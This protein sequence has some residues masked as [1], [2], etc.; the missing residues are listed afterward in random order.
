M[1][2]E[3]FVKSTFFTNEIGTGGISESKSLFFQTMLIQHPYVRFV[4]SRA[5]KFLRKKY[6]RPIDHIE[7]YEHDGND[8]K[9]EA[10]NPL[11]RLLFAF[12]DKR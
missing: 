12:A 6:R 5:Y 1:L 7:N 10:F 9:A 11:C 4:I 3:N 2:N 8:D